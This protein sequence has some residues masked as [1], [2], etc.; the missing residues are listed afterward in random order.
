MAETK[1]LIFGKSGW[2]GGLVAEEL[3]KQGLDF[4]LADSRL[5]NREGVIKDIERVKPTHVLNCAGVTGR[6]NVDWCEDHKVECI[7]GN[8]LGCINLAD[9]CNERGIHMTYFGTGCIF[10]YDKEFTIGGKGFKEEDKP[11]FTGSYYSHCKAITEDLLHAFPNVLTLRV[12]MPIVADLTYPRN[13]ITKIIKYHKVVNIPNSMTVLP[14]LIPLSIEMAKRKLT[15]PMNYTNPGA[16]SHNEILEMYKQYIDPEF[17]WDNFTIEEQAKVIVAP[18]SNNELDSTRMR[19]E[20]PDVLGI[21]ESLIKYVFEPNA[22]KKDD[23]KKEIDELRSE[24]RQPQ[25]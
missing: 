18:R 23:I 6:P 19:T 20:F 11:N 4:G 17:T 10:H 9:I 5:E 21:K 2:I 13:F 25:A 1:F 14:E 12:R 22:E 15:G 16:V 7:R 24:F 3:K 8:I